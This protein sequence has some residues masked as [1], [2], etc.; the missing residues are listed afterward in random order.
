[1]NIFCDC[2][3]FIDTRLNKFIINKIMHCFRISNT[4][5]NFFCVD[6]TSCQAIKHFDKPTRIMITFLEGMKGFTPLG[7]RGNM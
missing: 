2:Y 7:C 6:Q 3:D 1:M 4:N 5:N